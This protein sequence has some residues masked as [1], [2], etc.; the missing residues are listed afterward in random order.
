MKDAPKKPIH[1]SSYRNKPEGE[2]ETMEK[3]VDNSASESEAEVVAQEPSP[4]AWFWKDM[5][6]IVSAFLVAYLMII[7][8]SYSPDDSGFDRLHYAESIN[9]FGGETGAWI[10]SIIL[11]LFGVFGFSI[12]F[13]ILI[14]GWISL[15]IRRAESDEQALYKPYLLSLSGVLLM[16]L[17][18]SSMSAL[19]ISA[20]SLPMALP[21]S[22]GGVIGYELG[23]FLLRQVDLLMTTML[24]VSGFAFGISLLLR[25]SWMEILER[26]GQFTWQAFDKAQG[27]YQ[28]LKAKYDDYQTAKQAIAP[29]AEVKNKA[30]TNASE[31][32][33]EEVSS[34]GWFA[35]LKSFKLRNHSSTEP[36]EAT[37]NTESSKT[38][39]IDS[40]KLKPSKEVEEIVQRKASEQ[41]KS[42]NTKPVAVSGSESTTP[43]AEKKGVVSLADAK[44][45]R[46]EKENQQN[47]DAATT[48]TVAAKTEKESESDNVE[49]TASPVA[50]ENKSE[51]AN[52]TLES[53]TRF[54]SKPKIE[55]KDQIDLALPESEEALPTLE[56]NFEEQWKNAQL[57]EFTLLD[58]PREDK[59]SFSEKEVLELSELLEQRMKE[60]GV[61]VEVQSVT[62]GPVV[63]RF[64]ILPAPGVK[65][66]QISNLSKDLARVLSV[67]SVRVVEVIPGKSVVG[68]E[69]PNTVREVVSFREVL[70]SDEFN[71]AGSPLTVALGKDIS[72]KP[73]VANIAGMP[74]LLVAGTTGSGKSVGINTMILSMLY[75]ARPDQVRMIMIDPKMLE[76]SIYE[77]IPH[78]L[79]PVVTD[80]SEAANALRWSVFEMDRRYQLMSKVGVRNIIGYNNKVQEAIDKGQPIIDPLYEQA[81]NFGHNLGEKPPTLEPL[82]YIVVI[83]DEYA[84][85]IMVVGKE[86][87][88]LVTRIAQKA[89]AAGIHLILAT[90]RPSV[91]VITG[92]I[93]A[94]IPTRIS[95]M[96]NTKIDSR[97]ILDQGG[98][99]QLLGKGDMLFL[100]P[101]SGAPRRVHGAFMTD[102]EVHSVVDFVKS[103]GK[104]KYLKAITQSFEPEDSDN[105][106]GPKA[107]EDDLLFDEIVAWVAKEQRVSVSLIQRAFSIGYNRSARIVD[108]MEAQGMISKPSGGNSQREVLL[109]KPGND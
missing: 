86:I 55:E 87:E 99:E 35:K 56:E 94:N 92:V 71:D 59:N 83:I 76:L 77:D 16:L 13:S 73:V 66:S 28:W 29:K 101:G 78:L 2:I 60:F 38:D 22:S 89:R 57:P 64:E 107:A 7:L 43:P 44:N 51:K 95:F 1:I 103:Q 46:K 12:P 4:I 40:K 45:K 70:A 42:E 96:V 98:G 20:E 84:D 65:V 31:V 93:K 85:L 32:N 104:P 50:E 14:A 27:Y 109:P 97:T 52:E 68:I 67:S 80:M 90:Q 53:L 23:G 81:A 100:E 54:E 17:T 49:A 19:F 33:E 25:M 102:D 36:K 37:E 69:I 47:K 41:A 21:F 15:Q 108:A 82:P 91:S 58:E 11:Y 9:N 18:G 48:Q 10:S 26:T 63:T 88:Q 8:I 6:W 61:S 72:G 5:I 34:Q 3:S 62:P 75:K 79:T 106:S 30:N 39:D 24:L 105:S 74:H